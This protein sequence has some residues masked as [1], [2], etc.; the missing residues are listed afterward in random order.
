MTAVSVE[1]L[2]VWFG[3]ERALHD[4]SLEIAAG[5]ITA[6]LGAAGCGKSVLIRVMNRCAEVDPSFRMTGTVQIGGIDP[7]EGEHGAAEIRRMVG[8]V[9]RD[10][11]VFPV[12]IL[13]NLRFGLRSARVEE[14]QIAPRIEEALRVV[15]LWDDVRLRLN[16]P[17]DTL[18]ASRQRLLCLARA[19]VLQPK[20]LLVD[21]PGVG[22]DAVSLG[23]WDD[24]L[25]TIAAR[26]TLVMVTR[27]PQQAA[28]LA[29][30]TVFMADGRVVERGETL[31]LFTNPSEKATE[32]YLS[33]RHG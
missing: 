22:L 8:M 17:A 33:R 18:V 11:V 9:T 29:P 30:T 19:L 25:R 2:S 5:E 14:A 26:V 16:Q 23:I 31:T 28:R 32:A 15:G 24:V 10:S 12:S 1:N 3:S 13:E 27:S 20:V 7:Y 6:I 21:E 4:V